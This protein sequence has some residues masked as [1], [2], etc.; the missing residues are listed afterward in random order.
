[1]PEQKP[2]ELQNKWDVEVIQ[3][4]N[5]PEIEPVETFTAVHK[6]AK[7]N[8]E[9]NTVSIEA[10]LSADDLKGE[11]SGGPTPGFSS[12]SSG[13][14]CKVCGVRKDRGIICTEH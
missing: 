1:M 8:I 3:E 14:R 7:E 4:P 9:D 13:T 12:D 5:T 6:S 2:Q 11:V 10:A